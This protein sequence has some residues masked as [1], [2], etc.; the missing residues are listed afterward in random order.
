MEYVGLQQQITSNNRKSIL[1]LFGF[2]SIL[3]LGLYVVLIFLST[4]NTNE[5][6]LSATP[7]VL[8]FTGVW[9][10]IAYFGHSRMINYATGAKS[11]ERKENMRVYN[12]TE[13]LCMSVGMK[14]PILRII[15]STAL[16]AFASGLNEKNH[17]VTL[18]RG[19]IDK[20]DDDELEGVIAHELM[21][22]RNNDV[23]L[24]IISIVFV[25]IF[26]FILQLAFRS[27][28]FGGGRSRKKDGK[29][30]AGAIIV[31]LIASAVAYLISMV[32][33][34]ALSR[35]REYL[36]DAGAAEMTKNPLGLANALRKISGNSKIET[37]K[38]DDVKEMFIENGPGKNASS[39]FSGIR[40]IFSTH[41]PIEKRITLLEQ[42]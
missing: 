30:G 5:A 20:L 31:I 35:K 10:L 29:G 40:N 1:L 8:G 25:G 2:P 38:N 19:I 12:L 4:G 9:F 7:Y 26:S 27:F 11:L 42:F 36:A 22:I 16:N 41:P 34:F 28:I 15:E 39:L 37:I 24:L 32:F 14:I 6:F 33:K 3:L 13:N 18:T 21:H 17:T 23:R